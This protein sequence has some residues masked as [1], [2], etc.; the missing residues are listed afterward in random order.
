MRKRSAFPRTRTGMDRAIATAMRQ[1]EGVRHET[2]MPAS[3]HAGGCA[4]IASIRRTLNSRCNHRS[5][6]KGHAQSLR[7]VAGRTA[8]SATSL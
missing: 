5:S 7:A 4:I 6:R 3:G 1:I 8:G 2:G